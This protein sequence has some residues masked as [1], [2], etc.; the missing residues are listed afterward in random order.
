MFVFGLLV[1]HFVHS[2]LL[3]GGFWIWNPPPHDTYAKCIE[4]LSPQPST[5]PGFMMPAGSSAALIARIAAS[6]P[7]SP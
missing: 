5:A 7:G 4:E 6:F 1:E 3:D 2:L